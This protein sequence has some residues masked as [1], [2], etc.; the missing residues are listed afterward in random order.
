M[1]K[2]R[3]WGAAVAA[4][5]AVAAGAAA[6][7]AVG[8]PGTLPQGKYSCL[9]TK[10]TLKLGKDSYRYS[11]DKGKYAYKRSNRRVTFKTGPLKRYLGIW[12]PEAPSAIQLQRKSN[13]KTFAN[14]FGPRS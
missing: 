8:D 6:P 4:S 1:R 14:C 13:G 3:I 9:E 11:G 2:S 5:I 10:K 7:A 12:V